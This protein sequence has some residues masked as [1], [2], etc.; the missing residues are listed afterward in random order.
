MPK[1]SSKGNGQNGK[2]DSGN[3]MA[4][5]VGLAAIAAAAA[6]AYYFYGKNGAKRRKQLKGWAVKAKGELM[7]EVEKLKDISEAAY[8]HAVDKVLAKYKQ[9]KTVAPD[10]LKEFQTE[11][12]NSWKAVKA[13][14][15]KH[16]I[17]LKK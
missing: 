15:A 17:R 16:S 10:E 8:D 9:V 7:E 1:N 11:L 14:V 13:E 12:K 5:G 6:G 4:V 2:N 3:G